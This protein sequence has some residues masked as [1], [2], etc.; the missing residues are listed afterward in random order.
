MWLGK[1]SKKQMVVKMAIMV[2]S[3]KNITLK[4]DRTMSLSG[5]IVA[6]LPALSPDF[7]IYRFSKNPFPRLTRSV[8][9]S[10]TCAASF[11]RPPIATSQEL[12]MGTWWLMVVTLTSW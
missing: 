6:L 3:V 5:G 11:Q 7:S 9:R 12:V 1:K 8:R 4:K 2:A 10:R